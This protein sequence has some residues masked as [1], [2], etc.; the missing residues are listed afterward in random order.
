MKKHSLIF[1]I[2]ICI[3]LSASY[4]Q[5]K[6]KW[7]GKI[8][9]K[10]GI[11]V[12]INPKNPLY[13]EIV[14][15]LEEDLSIGKV[16]DS[17]YLFYLVRDIEV[18]NQGNIYVGDMSNCRVQKFNKDGK[19]IQTIGRQ[20]QGPGEFERP[21]KIRINEKSGNIYVQDSVYNIVIFDRHGNYLREVFVK[22][23]YSGL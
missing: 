23:K 4:S 11:K 16:D 19:Y 5:Q 3:F 14:F 13:G 6:A 1:V 10:D 18:D 17:N 15:D 12:I 2:F 9:S 20:G 8:E 21:T 7:K 22:K